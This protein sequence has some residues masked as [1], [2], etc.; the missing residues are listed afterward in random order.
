M[1]RISVIWAICAI[2]D[3]GGTARA[4]QVILD[5]PFISQV[6]PGD[7]NNTRNCGPTAALMLASYYLN[8]QPTLEDI[9]AIDDW[10]YAHQIIYPQYGIDLYNGNYTDFGDLADL[11]DDYFGLGASEKVY[12]QSEDYIKQQIRAG[13]P[14]IVAVRLNMLPGG[15][16]H[17]MLV[18]G[19]DDTGVIV[20]DPG[21][22]AENGGLAKHYDFNKFRSSWASW[23]N[24]SMHLTRFVTWH[25]NGTLIKKDA[26]PKIY[27]LL[28]GFKHHVKNWEVFL[29]HGFDSNKIVA[30]SQTELDCYAE[31]WAVDWKP[32]RRVFGNA[33]DGNYYLMEKMDASHAGCAIYRFASDFAAESWGNYL[34]DVSWVNASDAADYLTNCD[35]GADLFLRDGSLVKPEPALANFGYG[36]GA[37]FVIHDNGLASAFSDWQTFERMNYHADEIWSVSAAEFLSAIRDFDVHISQYDLNR[38]GG[39][40]LGSG[41]N[42]EEDAMYESYAGPENTV[43]VGQCLA[44]V[45]QCFGGRLYVISRQVLP[46]AE[47]EDG[48]DNDCDGETDEETGPL[49]SPDDPEP[50]PEEV[51][52]SGQIISS[53]SGDIST[54]GIGA[55]RPRI[56][57]CQNGQWVLIQQEI[58][59]Q[60]EQNDGLDNDCDGLLDDGWNQYPD[61]PQD[62]EECVDGEMKNIYSGPIATFGVGICRPAVE[63]CVDGYWE[64]AQ[65][66]ILPQIEVLDGLDNDCDGL[67]DENLE[68]EAD[69]EPEPEPDPNEENP[70]TPSGNVWAAKSCGQYCLAFA[71]DY[72]AGHPPVAV[73][74]GDFPGIDWNYQNGISMLIASDSYYHISLIGAPAGIYRVTYT[75]VSGVWAQYGDD[76][77]DDVGPF[78]WCGFDGNT[79][80]CSIKFQLTAGGQVLPAGNN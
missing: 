3:V 59:P 22:S 48:L 52:S 6:P 56:E 7:W 70:I 44:E 76:T 32:Y 53:Y 80:T 39:G 43:N 42:C 28:D 36:Q 24:A 78:R 17:F 40:D 9:K 13:N 41:S 61:P 62:D 5:V 12:A 55:C 60:A 67:A 45:K 29:A 58:L 68:P 37:V 50:E 19:F 27:M 30:V 69:P 18:I 73:L 66:E 77:L 11:L 79:H 49:N 57:Q 20:H 75:S 71:G 10:L 2:L 16:G 54:Y 1:K 25:P 14:V 33:G 4:E 38:C 26:D 74:V 23:S 64:L 63:E 46:E 21:H 15:P 8:D 47:I 35:L 31:S 72:L 65:P 51:C 34:P